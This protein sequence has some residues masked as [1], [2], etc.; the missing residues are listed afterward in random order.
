[1]VFII[2]YA[3]LIYYNIIII[4]IIGVAAAGSGVPFHFH[5]PGFA[6]TLHGRKRWFLYAPE[7]RPKFDTEKSTLRWL[8]EDYPQLKND[9]LMLECILEPFDIIYFPDRWWH[10]TLNVDNAVFISTFISAEFF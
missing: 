2:K 5:G 6:E 10:A 1:M 3:Y 9:G 4:I 8:V 7:N